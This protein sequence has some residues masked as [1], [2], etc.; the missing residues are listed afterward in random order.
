M[1]SIPSGV[2]LTER[3]DDYVLRRKQPDGTL[4]ELPLSQ[5]ELI[6]LHTQ[7]QHWKTR[8]LQSL[9][10]KSGTVRPIIA[11]PVAAMAVAPDAFREH[12]L[13]TTQAPTGEQMVL[14]LPRPVARKLAEDIPALLTEMGPSRGFQ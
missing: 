8:L 6:G 2:S 12:V 13:L 4:I 1:T 14:D 5:A 3:D 11:H 9:Q 7:L 10:D